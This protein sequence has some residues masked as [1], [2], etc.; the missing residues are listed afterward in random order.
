MPKPN[1]ALLP[2]PALFDVTHLAKAPIDGRIERV[3]LERA[4]ARRRTR[5]A[6]SPTRGSSASPRCCAHRPARAVH[7]PP[8]RPDAA[9][10]VIYDGQRRYLAAKASH[11]LA[12]S[13]GYEGLAAGPQPDRA[14]AR[15]R[16]ERRTRSA[17]SRRRPTSARALSLVDQQEQ[18]AR[19]LGGPRRAARGRPDRRRLRRPRDL[20]QARAQPPPPARRSPTR[21][22]PASPN[23]RPASRSR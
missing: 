3:A 8:P 11:E 6:R 15:P 21:S 12:G 2:R 9:R 13:D 20:A 18:F 22:A 16:A 14:A 10:T 4:R 23:A 19:L 17:A 7:R 5:G 1:P